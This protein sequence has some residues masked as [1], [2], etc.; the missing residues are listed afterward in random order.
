MGSKFAKGCTEFISKPGLESKFLHIKSWV[1]PFCQN[2]FLFSPP[3]PLLPL[4]QLSHKSL[5][6]GHL[7]FKRQQIPALGKLWFSSASCLECF[8]EA[9]HTTADSRQGGNRAQALERRVMGDGSAKQSQ[10][11]HPSSWPCLGTGWERTVSRSACRGQRGK[12]FL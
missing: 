8:Q 12:S 3:F 6:P 2:K 9:T 10:R 5:Q 7:L 11:A 4:L 1:H